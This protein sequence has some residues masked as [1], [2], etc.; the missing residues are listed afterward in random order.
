[1]VPIHMHSWEGANLNTK[2]SNTEIHCDVNLIR[3]DDQYREV[4]RARPSN[5]EIMKM[6]KLAALRGPTCSKVAMD[7]FFPC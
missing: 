5:D 4:S 7:H 3:E 1:M 6:P 2:A